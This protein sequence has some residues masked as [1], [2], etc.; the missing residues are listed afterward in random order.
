MARP[1]QYV[2]ELTAAEAQ[3]FFDDILNPTPNPARDK[4]IERARHFNVKVVR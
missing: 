4:T 3:R 1:I 2:V